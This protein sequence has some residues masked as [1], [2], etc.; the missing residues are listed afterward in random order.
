MDTFHMGEY[1]WE[2]KFKF[3]VIIK[4]KLTVHYKSNALLKSSDKVLI[5]YFYK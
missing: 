1:K 5:V 4:L 3:S 2:K